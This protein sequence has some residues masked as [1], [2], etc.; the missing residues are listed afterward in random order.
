[1]PKN[2]GHTRSP[3]P[4]AVVSYP[5]AVLCSLLSASGF[6]S[7]PIRKSSFP[8]TGRWRQV[9]NGGLHVGSPGTPAHSELRTGRISLALDRV[10]AWQSGCPR[11]PPFGVFSCSCWQKFKIHLQGTTFDSQVR[12]K[13][14]IANVHWQAGWSACG[15]RRSRAHV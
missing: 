11:P 10:T 15:E 2:A 3:E 6:V 5:L 1:M 8:L 13:V 9:G 7:P 12:G 14:S 4:C